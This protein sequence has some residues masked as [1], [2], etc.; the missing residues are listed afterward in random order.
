MTGI[1]WARRSLSQIGGLTSR[2]RNVVKVV[3][4]KGN[5]S[6]TPDLKTCNM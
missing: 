2:E 6:S 3:R 4:S 5:F 1:K